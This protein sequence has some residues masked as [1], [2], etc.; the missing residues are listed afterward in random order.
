[1]NNI[2]LLMED[3][4]KRIKEKREYGAG[5]KE[6]GKKREDTEKFDSY[7]IKKYMIYLQIAIIDFWG[8][9][10]T[11]PCSDDNEFNINKLRGKIINTFYL[12]DKE[13]LRIFIGKLKEYNIHEIDPHLY[14]KAIKRMLKNCGYYEDDSPYTFFIEKISIKGKQLYRVIF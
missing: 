8:I 10:G 11:N 9:R 6:E 4:E 14:C 5:C 1:M 12:D 2:Q 13:L 7:L 3:L